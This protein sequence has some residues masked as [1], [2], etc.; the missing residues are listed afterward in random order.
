[1]GPL[2]LSRLFQANQCNFFFR[3]A[4]CTEAVNSLMGMAVSSYLADESYLLT[5]GEKV[6]THYVKH[7]HFRQT[8]L[9]T[10]LKIVVLF[11]VQ[12]M[13]GDVKSVFE[14]LVA[15]LTWMDPPTKEATLQKVRA[16]KSFVGFPEWLLRA[17]DMN[18]YYEGVRQETFQTCNT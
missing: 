15:E 18:K 5:T 16:M 4:V 1:M 8:A 10:L 9:G 3:E 12:E 6:N 7:V 14:D 17:E 2:L 13:L 11:Q